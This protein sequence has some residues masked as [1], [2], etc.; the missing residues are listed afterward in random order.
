MQ[1]LYNNGYVVMGLQKN[2]S[3]STLVNFRGVEGFVAWPLRNYN[4]SLSKSLEDE[5]W[6]NWFGYEDVLEV[7]PQNDYLFR[8]V[9]HC[10]SNKINTI[11]MQIESPKCNQITTE[12]LEIIEVLGYDCITGVQLS[13]LNLLPDFLKKHFPTTY[14]KLNSN[15]LCDNIEDI[16]FFL[17]TYNFLLS[18]GMD[19]EHGPNPIPAKLSIVK[20]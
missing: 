8:Y 19:L 1:S 13:Y 2:E 18:Q 3:S 20:L 7:V 10:K 12:P 17:D 16:Y 4:D 14:L 6:D 11:I 5:A 9:N 15:G